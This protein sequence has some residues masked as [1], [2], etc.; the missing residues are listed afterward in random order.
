MKLKTCLIVISVAATPGF[1][2][3]LGCPKGEDKVT[4]SSCAIGTVW[5]AAKK[6]A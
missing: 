2:F 1:A 5:D 3:A 6:P 4:A